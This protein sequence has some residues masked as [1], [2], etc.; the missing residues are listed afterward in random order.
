VV[1]VTSPEPS[2][3]F[4]PVEFDGFKIRIVQMLPYPQK[5]DGI[6]I[7]QPILDDVVRSARLL[8]EGVAADLDVH[9]EIGAHVE[10]GIDV[11]QFQP[12]LGLD[13]LPQ[14]SVLQ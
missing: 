12:A 11:N 5:L 13:L 3:F 14:W 9:R 8:G 1:W 4:K 7:S 10:G 2:L 6:A